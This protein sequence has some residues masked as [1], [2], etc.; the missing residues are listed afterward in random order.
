MCLH[1]FCGGEAFA[2]GEGKRRSYI[3]VRITVMGLFRLSYMIPVLIIWASPFHSNFACSNLSDLSC[4]GERVVVSAWNPSASGI[5]ASAARKRV[6]VWDISTENAGGPVFSCGLSEEDAD[7]VDMSWA[8]NGSTL[9][10]TTSANSIEIIDP[11]TDAATLKGVEVMIHEYGGI[12]DLFGS[13]KSKTNS[14]HCCYLL[15]RPGAFAC[16]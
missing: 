6:Y 5:L 7:I 3:N 11:R 15:R 1:R 8:A 16:I 14:H 4:D 12:F 13:C 10:A 2:T 9:I